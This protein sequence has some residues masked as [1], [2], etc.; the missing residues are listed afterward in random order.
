[1]NTDKLR[2]VMRILKDDGWY[3]IR[4]V[5]SHKQFKHT[6]KKGTVTVADHPGDLSTKDLK[7]IEKQAGIKFE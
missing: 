2:E 5:G 6:S 4:P 7:Q 3:F 1:M